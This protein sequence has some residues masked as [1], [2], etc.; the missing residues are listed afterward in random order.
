MNRDEELEEIRQFHARCEKRLTETGVTERG[1]T[2]RARLIAIVDELKR[3]RDDSS[4]KKLRYDYLTEFL[5][6]SGWDKTI[7]I[8]DAAIRVTAAR[9]RDGARCETCLDT[10]GRELGLVG[11]LAMTAAA[12]VGKMQ[13]CDEVACSTAVET[14]DATS[15]FSARADGGAHAD[16]RRCREDTNARRAD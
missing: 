16:D 6:S 8:R 14:D 11:L 3:E 15:S 7:E 13:V 1:H 5:V 2:V 4:V 12:T 10:A 9:R